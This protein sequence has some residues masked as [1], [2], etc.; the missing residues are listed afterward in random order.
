MGGGAGAPR[1]G[2][3]G[4]GFA[5]ASPP[6]SALMAAGLT[7]RRG[8]G[9]GVAP[10]EPTA[11]DT[12][13]WDGGSLLKG[14]P[15]DACP[16]VPAGRG[17]RGG[18]AAPGRGRAG[19]FAP[20]T[21]PTAQAGAAGT[22]KAKSRQRRR[23][24]CPTRAHTE[25]CRASEA[26][27][28]HE[29]PRGPRSGDGREEPHGRREHPQCSKMVALFIRPPFFPSF[30]V[31]VADVFHAHLLVLILKLSP[32]GPA[33]FR[34]LWKIGMTFGNPSAVRFGVAAPAERDEVVRRVI[35]AS[36]AMHDMMD[37]QAAHV[38]AQRAAVAVAGVDGLSRLVWDGCG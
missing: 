13:K 24:R 29:R 4:R 35:P 8:G 16:G 36:A 38:I 32:S 27:Q 17:Q 1:R 37:L 6:H 12:K 25:E 22:E 7:G 18:A 15:A 19:F 21:T 31:E 33:L 3:K 2:P 10:E 9:G 5:D 28:A 20:A 34:R 11:T 26:A 14:P 23:A 30:G